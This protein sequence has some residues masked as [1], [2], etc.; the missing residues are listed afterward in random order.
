MMIAV[1]DLTSRR[2]ATHT[3]AL[4][5]DIAGRTKYRS[6]VRVDDILSM[7]RYS[8]RMSSCSTWRTYSQRG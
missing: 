3:E 2:D 6:L 5:V 8:L 7:S 1:D 4:K